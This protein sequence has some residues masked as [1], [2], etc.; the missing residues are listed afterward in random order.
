MRGFGGE[1]SRPTPSDI[2]DFP[3]F[4][5]LRRPFPRLAQRKAQKAGLM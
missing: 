3:Q 4:A 1:S 2:D 5:K